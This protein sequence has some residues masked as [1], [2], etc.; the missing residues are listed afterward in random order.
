MSLLAFLGC[1]LLIRFDIIDVHVDFV[2]RFRLAFGRLLLHLGSNT[3]FSYIYCLDGIED[4]LVGLS[5]TLAQF[6]AAR[7]LQHF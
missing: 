7:L 2:D 1:L 6:V 5:N 4:T 3:S